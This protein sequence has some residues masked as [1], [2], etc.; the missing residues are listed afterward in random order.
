MWSTIQADHPMKLLEVL[1]ECTVRLIY[2]GNLRFGVLMW[3][4]RLPKKVA[5]KSPA[6]NIVEEY[7]LQDT[8]PTTKYIDQPAQ[9][10][11]GTSSSAHHQSRMWLP[12]IQISILKTTYHHL[13]MPPVYLM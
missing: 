2:L 4:P 6:F 9:L 8:E 11:V 3:K 1:Q 5:T 10:H 12:L 7:T 13:Q